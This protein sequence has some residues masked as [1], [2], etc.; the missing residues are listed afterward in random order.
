VFIEFIQ[1]IFNNYK[2]NLS[3]KNERS[4]ILLILYATYRVTACSS[5]GVHNGSAA[6]EVE[7]AGIRTTHRTA[8][9]VAVGPNIAERTKAVAA[10]ARHGQFKRRGKSPCTIITAPT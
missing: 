1:E 3:P 9:I 4:F 2:V 8:P 5:V 10:E 7:D 6:T